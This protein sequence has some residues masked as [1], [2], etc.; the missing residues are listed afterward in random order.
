V[1]LITASAIYLNAF[2]VGS[3]LMGFEM[4]GS[5]YL[6]PYFGGGIGTW[7]GLISMVLIALTIGYS[8]GGSLVDRFPTTRIAAIA[9]VLAALYLAAIPSTADHVMPWILDRI[10]DGPAGVLAAPAALLLLPMSL[11][12][13][14]SPIGI[15][16]LVR[17]TSESGR[18]AG[19][20]YGISTVGNV[21]GVLVT[22]FY[23]IPT[24]GSRAITYL[25]SLVL[26]A[27]AIML[28]SIPYAATRAAS[29]PERA[30][31]K[32]GS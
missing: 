17:T 6:F 18:V 9:I 7:A 2:L 4:L 28:F 10:G 22:T 20:V 27:C 3:V 21:F 8:I 24:I 19:F 23:L 26:A 16:L 30:T 5:R 11:L 1:R 13:T 15:R 25:F 14:L 32:P 31:G 29:E 12:G